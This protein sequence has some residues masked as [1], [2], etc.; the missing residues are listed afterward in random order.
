MKKSIR[1][2]NEKNAKEFAK[3]VNG[4]LKD[5]RG[6]KDAKSNFKVTFE[7]AKNPFYFPDHYTQEDINEMCGFDV[8]E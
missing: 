6:L 8:T 4:V 1:F 3:K 5:L 7:K 2:T